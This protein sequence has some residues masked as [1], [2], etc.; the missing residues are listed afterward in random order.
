MT[1]ILEHLFSNLTPEV[2]HWCHFSLEILKLSE[3]QR[4]GAK[5]YI[6]TEIV[7][8]DNKLNKTYYTNHHLRICKNRPFGSKPLEPAKT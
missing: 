1:Q 3:L 8:I 2:S 4:K 6:T 7:R 5:A